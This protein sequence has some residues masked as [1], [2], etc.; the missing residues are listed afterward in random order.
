VSASQNDSLERPRCIGP[1]LLLPQRVDDDATLSAPSFFSPHASTSPTSFLRWWNW[2]G[3]NPK[4]VGGGRLRPGGLPLVVAAPMV[5]T[6]TLASP[7][8]A[9]GEF[10]PCELAPGWVGLGT[11]WLDVRASPTPAVPSHP[12]A[13]VSVARPVS[14][15][16]R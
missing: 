7:T 12:Q 15:E 3:E 9:K 2:K 1:R 11:T 8:G 6:A 14:G 16:K 5:A 10:P 13:R 4:R